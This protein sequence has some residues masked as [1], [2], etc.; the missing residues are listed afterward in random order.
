MNNMKKI[1]RSELLDS[2]IIVEANR[3]FFHPHGLDISACENGKCNGLHIKKSND[4]TVEYKTP[5]TEEEEDLYKKASKEF[6][7]SFGKKV[8]DVQKIESNEPKQKK[9]KK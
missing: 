1:T 5:L 8:K 6:N 3:Q 4:G 7:D 2:G 9:S